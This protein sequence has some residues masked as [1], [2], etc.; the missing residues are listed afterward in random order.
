MI[1]VDTNIVVA[2]FIASARTAD[3]QRLHDNDAVWSTEPFALVEFANVLATYHRAKLIT[4]NNATTYLSHARELLQDHFITVDPAS[5]LEVAM[6][7]NVSAYDAHFLAV[8]RERGLKLTTE[9]AKLRAA[10]PQLTQSL[11]QTMKALIH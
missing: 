7:F 10:A 11:D 9:D 6:Q 5:A 4:S 1:V 8:A 2:L 3:A